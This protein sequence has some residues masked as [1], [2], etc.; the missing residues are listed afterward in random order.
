MNA[1]LSGPK[2]APIF[3]GASVIYSIIAL[4]LVYKKAPD[5]FKVRI[6]K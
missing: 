5:T 2:V 6:S 4:V 1:R 3:I